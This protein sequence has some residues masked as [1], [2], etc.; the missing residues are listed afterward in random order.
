MPLSL[1]QVPL[2]HA[3]VAPLLMPD[4]P[5][6]MSISVSMC[7]SSSCSHPPFYL[8]YRDEIADDVIIVK[9]R[10]RYVKVTAISVYPL[11]VQ[12]DI[13]PRATVAFI[14]VLFLGGKSLEMTSFCPLSRPYSQHFA[15]LEA[16]FQLHTGHFAGLPT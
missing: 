16:A 14:K 11:T 1:F 4:S 13:K 3:T 7:L 2:I 5:T 12:S 9:S 10:N 8:Q 6:R 15:L